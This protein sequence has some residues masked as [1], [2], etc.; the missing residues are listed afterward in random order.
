MEKIHFGYLIILVGI[1]V[2]IGG[3]VYDFDFHKRN[4]GLTLET[5]GPFAIEHMP[6]NIGIIIV[7]IGEFIGVYYIFAK[8]KNRKPVKRIGKLH[9]GQ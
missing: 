6:F 7:V 4:L 1:V 5:E 3:F 8:G 9:V 2:L